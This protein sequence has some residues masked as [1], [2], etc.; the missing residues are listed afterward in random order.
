M[1]AKRATGAI[2]VGVLA[3]VSA[4]A[5]QNLPA[6]KNTWLAQRLNARQV[7]IYLLAAEPPC[8]ASGPPLAPRYGPDRLGRL[9]ALRPADVAPLVACVTRQRM[10]P[11]YPPPAGLHLGQHFV[12]LLGG[13]ATV[14]LRLTGFAEANGGLE[15]DL[16]G[17]AT[18]APGGLAAFHGTRRDDFLAQTEGR[19]PAEEGAARAALSVPQLGAAQRAALAAR[20]STKTC[21]AST[22]PGCMRAWSGSGKRWTTVWQRGTGG[23]NS[24]FRP[25]AWAQGPA[26]RCTGCGR[27]GELRGRPRDC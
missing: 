7:V 18:I 12:L 10:P 19:F 5:A 21:A 4:V 6:P 24:I 26:S 15:N 17:V 2:A 16:L 20:R 8:G 14:P 3:A 22:G 13:S 23:C 27:S 9:E 1:R 11:P 25:S